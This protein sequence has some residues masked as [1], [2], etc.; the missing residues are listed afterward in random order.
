MNNA[1]S[2]VEIGPGGWVLVVVA[3]LATFAVLYFLVGDDFFPSFAFS[4]AIA[5]IVLLLLYRLA[6][7]ISRYEAEDEAANRVRKIVPAAA[8]VE[9]GARISGAEGAAAPSVAAVRVV[10]ER[11][12]SVLL[13]PP[14]SAVVK[15]LSEVAPA[16]LIA[17]PQPVEPPRPKEEPKPVVVAA[18]AEPKVVAKPKAKPKADA[19]P[20]V[21]ASGWTTKP[22]K[23]AAAGPVRLTAPRKGGA[24]DLKQILGIGPKLEILCHK[25]GFFHFDQIAA[26]TPSE[27][28]WVDDNLEGF[29]GRV[30]RDKWVM[31]AR[32]LA[33]GGSVEEAERAARA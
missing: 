27:I 10:P 22:G 1:E 2:D 9:G 17:P 6:A 28:A 19:K 21:Q 31:Q 33:A 15:P 16:P 24:D 5:L 4:L 18:K 25:L 3:G 26:W 32:I 12:K 20:K 7:A 14:T 23:A 11:P 8:P 29:K 13:N 30:T